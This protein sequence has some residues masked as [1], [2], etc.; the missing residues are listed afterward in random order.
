[1]QRA[2][3]VLEEGEKI[4]VFLQLPRGRGMT[5]RPKLTRVEPNREMRWLGRLFMPGL[6]DGEHIFELH[7]TDHGGT[8]F[9]Q[10]EYVRG[11]LGRPLLA[12]MGDK[13]LR[14]FQQMNE[15][16]KARAEEVNSD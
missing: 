6:F 15:A 12:M 2:R 10:R 14:G 1:M 3:G 16:L 9:V 11:L 4:E 8:R 7:P 13:T 5:F